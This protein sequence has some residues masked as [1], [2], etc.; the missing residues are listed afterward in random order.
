MSRQLVQVFVGVFVALLLASSIAAVA[1]AGAVRTPVIVGYDG[2]FADASRTIRAYGGQVDQAY[3]N[4]PVVA[5]SVPMRAVGSLASARGISFVEPVMVRQVDGHIVPGEL[6]LGVPQIMPWGVEA[7]RAPEAWALSPARGAGVRVAVLD[8]GFDLDHPDLEA[9]FLAG[10]DFVDNDADPSDT[11]GPFLGHGTLTSGNIAAIDNDVGVVGVAPNAK[12]LPYRVCDSLEGICFTNAIIGAIDRAVSDGAG[13]ISMSFSGPAAS[14]GETLA[15]RAAY[16]AGVVLVASSGNAGRPPVGCPACLPQV[17]AVGATD[18]DNAL[19]DFSSF[20]RNQ[21][22]VGPGVDVPSTTFGG[23][24]R[25]AALMQES[26]MEAGLQANPFEFSNTTDADGI[27]ASLAFA[28]LGT[29]SNVADLDLTGKI[30]LIQRGSITFREKVANV[31]SRG[32]IGAVIFNNL[33]GNF[34]GTLGEPSDLPAVSLSMAEGL[35][36]KAQLDAGATVVVTLIVAASDYD[37]ASGTSFSAPHVSGVAALVLA[38]MAG[39]TNVQARAAMDSTATDLGAAGYDRFYG[40]GLVNA[41]AAVDA[42]LP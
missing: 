3:V 13:V 2:S 6:W 11:E 39:V 21:E 28:G 36:L 32:A 17:I 30:A 15:I 10:W 5:A 41:E 18:I 26:P 7:V 8:T 23:A 16:A 40:F 1:A 42:V 20:G 27:T 22:L 31:E 4:F 35:G 14:R 19:A 12:I 25:E 34:F 24:G 29:A 9:N 38:A 33:A 37:T